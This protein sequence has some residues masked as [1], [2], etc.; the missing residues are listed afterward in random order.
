VIVQPV[1]QLEPAQAAIAVGE[2]A[3]SSN[4]TATATPNE[5]HAIDTHLRNLVRCQA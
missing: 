2:V 5:P 4:R 3:A 1:L